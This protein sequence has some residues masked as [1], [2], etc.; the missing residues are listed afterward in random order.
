MSDLKNRTALVTGASKGIGAHLASALAAAGAAVVVN[1]RTDAAGAQRVVDDIVAAGGQ[2]LAVQGDVGQRA[3]VEAMF[4]AARNAFG[5]V[6]IL[7]NNAAVVAFAPLS[8]LTEED[9]HRQVDTNV[10]GPLLTMQAFAA[11]DDLGRSASIV[12]ISTAG[13]STHPPF[14]SVYVATKSALNSAT[15]VAARELAPR[16]VRV[17][18]VAPSASDTDGTRAM[19]FPGS[20]AAEAAVAEIPLGRL[21]VPEDYGQVVAFLASDAA[22]WITG[23][24]LFVSGGQR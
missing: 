16:G 5:P 9:F 23:E 12:N 10:L 22:R 13:T 1:Y 21:G 3:D 14:S 7:V 15:R 4:T 11:Q 19:G 17:N 24:V 2:A 8:A 18:A 6:D 20:P